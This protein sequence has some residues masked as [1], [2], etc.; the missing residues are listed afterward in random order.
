MAE[1]TIIAA[2]SIKDIERA[3]EIETAN[4]NP[5]LSVIKELVD[6]S[7]I[8][9]QQ[10][11]VRTRDPTIQE[12][13]SQEVGKESK[14]KQALLGASTTPVRMMQGVEG[15]LESLPAPIMGPSAMPTGRYS[16]PTLPPSGKVFNSPEDI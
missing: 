16:A 13:V 7:K 15:A 1:T 3:I 2:P 12:R 4:P 11:G 9:L 14:F 10:A 5:N 8:I 6:A